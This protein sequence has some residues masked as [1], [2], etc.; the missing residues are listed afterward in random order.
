M[1]CF[2]ASSLV[3]CLLIFF[4]S[5]STF[6]YLLETN[7]TEYKHPKVRHLL[8]ITR[9]AEAVPLLVGLLETVLF[10]ESFV[11]FPSPTLSASGFFQDL[12][13][14]L[15]SALRSMGQ[16]DLSLV[17]VFATPELQVSYFKFL[18]PM[19][20]LRLSFLYY[21]L[22]CKLLY[23]ANC[24]KLGELGQRHVVLCGCLDACVGRNPI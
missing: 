10:T 6:S 14:L 21:F 1:L 4:I 17:Q 18:V 24:A 20:L 22:F 8:S 12:V 7:A 23:Y 13:I 16:A 2:R 5:N 15:S 11:S 9:R 19:F 3:I